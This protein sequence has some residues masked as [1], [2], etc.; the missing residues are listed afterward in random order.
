MLL[1]IFQH[2]SSASQV[3]ELIK[4]RK[5]EDPS[6]I[7]FYYYLLR[8]CIVVGSYE[9]RVAELPFLESARLLK[10]QGYEKVCRQYLGITLAPSLR[11]GRMRS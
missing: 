1:L 4:D 8:K 5:E 7:T 10:V 9:E 6:G 3:A 2:K 11:E